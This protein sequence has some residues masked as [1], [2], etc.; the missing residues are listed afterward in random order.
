MNVRRLI[1]RMMRARREGRLPDI[2]EEQLR[3][4]FG[5]P[6][7]IRHTRS[8]VMCG[9]YSRYCRCGRDVQIGTPEACLVALPETPH[10]FVDDV[11]LDGD[12]VYLR[13]EDCPA[14]R[15]GQGDAVPGLRCT[16]V[17]RDA[18]DPEAGNG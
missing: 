11:R 3:V 2:P 17:A 1:A 13:A 10:H 9:S 15:A 4:Y 16:D 18:I 6:K 5:E 14:G 7:M 8:S 12:G